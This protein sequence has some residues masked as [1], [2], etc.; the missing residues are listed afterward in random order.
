MISGKTSMHLSLVIRPWKQ[1]G[2]EG[3]GARKGIGIFFLC[4]SSQCGA[5]GK[6]LFSALIA[7]LNC[8]SNWS[9]KNRY[10][11]LIY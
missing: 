3:E 7:R 9:V 2:L 1:W 10:S 11:Y 5:F 4:P 6:Y 8:F